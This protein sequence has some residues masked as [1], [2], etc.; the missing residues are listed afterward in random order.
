MAKPFFVRLRDSLPV[1]RKTTQGSGRRNA[2][3][4]Y[5]VG[6]TTAADRRRRL[7]RLVSG[8]SSSE[9]RRVILSPA[10][11]AVAL[12]T[13][14]LLSALLCIHLWPN[15]VDLHLG[16]TANREIVAQRSVRFEDTSATAALREDAQE[17]VANQYETIPGATVAATDSVVSV[18]DLVD[19]AADDIRRMR[20][21]AAELIPSGAAKAA[22]GVLERE[23]AKQLLRELGNVSGT[24]G[25]LPDTLT[26]QSSR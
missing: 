15:R 5:I 2:P 11:T 13:V 17:R 10:R 25:P 16:D 26:V 1:R 9:T 3:A 12:V 24:A 22:P 14:A 20:R 23:R 4:P 8:A 21:D 18:F 7:R 6:G 19:A